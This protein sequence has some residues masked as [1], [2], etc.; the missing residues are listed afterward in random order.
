MRREHY[1]ARLLRALSGKS[2]EKMAKEVGIHPVL[3]SQIEVGGVIPKREY[4]ETMAGTEG[5]TLEDTEELLEL[6]DTLRRT[7][8]KRTRSAEPFARLDDE[9]RDE[10]ARA[11]RRLLALP[12]ER[13]RAW[14]CRRLYEEAAHEPCTE[15][16]AA[17]L[18]QVA[19]AIAQR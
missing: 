15:E 8:R 14:I 6:A 2:Q 19:C 16:T 4:I 9:L 11:R 1:Q 7:N 18:F 10:V 13:L 3:L 12:A 17:A 5:L